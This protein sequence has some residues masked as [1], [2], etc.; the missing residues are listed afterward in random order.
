[1]NVDVDVVDLLQQRKPAGEF[2]SARVSQRIQKALKGFDDE[3]GER[4]G[5]CSRWTQVSAQPNI[6]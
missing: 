2:S 5:R 6:R 3:P 1:M 4:C